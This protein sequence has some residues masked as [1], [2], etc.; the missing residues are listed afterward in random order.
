MNVGYMLPV[1]L[2][3]FTGSYLRPQRQGSLFRTHNSVLIYKIGMAAHACNP[4]TWE[5]EA[6]ER[7]FL[8]CSEF[9]ASL[10]SKRRMTNSM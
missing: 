9:K 4:R 1:H 2:A 6:G 8:I 3:A 10:N 7:V 5:I